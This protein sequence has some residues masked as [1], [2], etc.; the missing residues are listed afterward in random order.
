MNDV[1]INIGKK[2]A[3][4]RKSK[5]LSIS[6]LAETTKLTSSLLSQI[7]RSLANPSIN[8]LKLISKALDVPIYRFFMGGEDEKNFIL[9]QNDRKKIVFPGNNGFTYELLTPDNNHT[10]IEFIMMKLSQGSS[11]S[12][13]PMA[14][15]GE[16]VALVTKGKVRLWL[17]NE[18]FILNKGDSV[19]IE[20]GS[21]HMWENPFEESS[22]VIFAVTPP[23]F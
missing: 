4:F 11:S 8:T 5:G 15:R 13:M 1:K 2:I 21:T 20:S 12:E 22:T 17:H 6:E 10:N 3:E 16:E 9:R 7:E 18:E 14:H 23:S 19:I